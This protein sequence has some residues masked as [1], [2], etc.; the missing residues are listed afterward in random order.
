MCQ[1]SPQERG[2][3]GDPTLVLGWKQTWAGGGQVSPR[4][5]LLW[6]PSQ[7]QG[8]DV[9]KL[10]CPGV[11]PYANVLMLAINACLRTWTI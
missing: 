3:E 2:R 5:R 11:S 4:P 9:S 6:A 8:R 7:G 1:P 10:S